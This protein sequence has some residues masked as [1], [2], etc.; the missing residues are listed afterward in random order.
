MRMVDYI[1]VKHNVTKQ[2]LCDDIGE[3]VKDYNYYL[4]GIKTPP[5]WFTLKVIKYFGIEE[6]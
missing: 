1:R 2:R 5:P 6:F 3:E 4:D